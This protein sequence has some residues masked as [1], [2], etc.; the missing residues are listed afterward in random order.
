MKTRA[1]LG[2]AALALSW[3]A[4]AF[5]N[6]SADG[7]GDADALAT[8]RTLFMAGKRA[9]GTPLV[10]M[11]AGGFTLSGAE[12]ACVNCHRRSGFG[13]SEG[14]SYIPPVNAASLFEAMLPGTGASASGTGRQA[15]THHTLARAI[16]AGIDHSGRRLDFLMPRYELNEAE[17]TSLIAYL[18]QLSTSAS[19]GVGAEALDFATI[20]APGAEP[21]RSKAMVE[22]LNACFDAHNAGPPPQRGRKRLGPDVKFGEQRKWKLHVWELAGEPDSWAAQ[23]ADYARRNPVFA[24]VGGIGGGNWAP[25]HEFCE[26]DGLPCLFPH[27]EVPVTGETGFY[28]LYLSR[29]VL[30]EAAIVARHLMEQAGGGRRVIQ[31]LRAEDEAARAAAEAVRRTLAARGIE[32]EE[33]RIQA[34]GG[35]DARL[36]DGLAPSDALVLWLRA[37][38]LKRLDAVNPVPGPVYLSAMLGGL[39]QAPLPV[40][41]KAR[42]FMAY[43]YELPQQ[44][45]ARTAKLHAWLHAHGLSPA[46]ETVQADAY[47]ACSALGAGM[48]EIGDHVH[49]DYLVERFEVIMGRGG[50]SGHYPN[51][52]F[53]AGQRFSSK[54]GYL[55]RFADPESARIASVGER[56][57][58]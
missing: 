1:V 50:F 27:V 43:P 53:G 18:R 9:D 24:V 57:A 48:N 34:G 46:D 47:I 12:A 42:A 51:L 22:V 13:G 56:M 16:R 36:F 55:V 39:E 44:R 19:P 49:R 25:V 17:M 33:R 20:V 7:P 32:T 41:W 6:A 23:L 14:R 15:Y 31:L 8:G 26:R 29:G 35:V 4:F 28:A 40:A 3:G 52:S 38:D 10:A 21:A 2:V 54:T 11:R 58:P 30:L 5:A 45:E 37:D